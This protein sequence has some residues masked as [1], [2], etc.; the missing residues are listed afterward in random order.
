MLTLS[1][2]DF[3]HLAIIIGRLN[4]Q[5]YNGN[6]LENGAFKLKQLQQQQLTAATQ[7]M[8]QQLDHDRSG[9]SVDHIQRVVRLTAKICHQENVAV[10]VPL[11]A[12]TLHDVIDDKV[13]ANVAQARVAL[14]TFLKQQKITSKDQQAVWQ[15]IDHLSFSANLTQHYHLSVAGQI[16]QDADRLDAIG[17]LGIARAFYYGGHMGQPLYDPAVPPR[18]Q[19][20]K[21][22]Y[23]KQDVPVINHFYEKLLLLKEQLNTVSGKQIAEKRQRMMLTFL[24][25]FKLEWQ[26]KA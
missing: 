18:Q 26:G 13:V 12:A 8:K 7:Y 9:H 21:A 22:A 19:L 25:E 2:Q 5:P 24:T 3:R 15:I 4:F 10:F 1:Y 11:L 16:V 17:A 14:A 23:R 6:S 20:D